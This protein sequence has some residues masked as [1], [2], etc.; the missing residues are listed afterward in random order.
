MVSF[1]DKLIEFVN[2]PIVVLALTVL[3]GMI[4]I[5]WGLASGE[6]KEIREAKAEL[7]LDSKEGFRGSLH[8]SQD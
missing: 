1:T 5:V 7:A 3:I 6:S 8:W 4:G 2:L